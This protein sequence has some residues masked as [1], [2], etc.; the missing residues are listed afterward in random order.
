MAKTTASGK[1][2]LPK[3]KR[4]VVKTKGSRASSKRVNKKFKSLGLAYSNCVRGTDNSEGTTQ[5]NG[6]GRCGLSRLQQVSFETI[7]AL[8]QEGCKQYFI[9]HGVLLPEDA[10]VN[11]KCWHCAHDLQVQKVSLTCQK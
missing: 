5:C 7:V 6:N 2:R 8:D 11:M 3:L 10:D 9:Q 1:K 4:K